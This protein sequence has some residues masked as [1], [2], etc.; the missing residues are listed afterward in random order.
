MA[1]FKLPVFG[2]LNQPVTSWW[3]GNQISISLGES[4]SPDTEAEVLRRVGTYGRQ[5]G[6]ITDGMIVL[7][8]HSPKDLNLSDQESEA[9]DAFKDM[10]NDIAKIK[11]S[12]KLKALRPTFANPNSVVRRGN[13]TPSVR[14]DED[15]GAP[16]HARQPMPRRRGRACAQL[17]R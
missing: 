10:A 14:R 15:A 1:V 2:D 6:Q 3:S 13:G 4:G 16:F 12:H 9:I 11:E 7:L 5:L 8:N 17:R